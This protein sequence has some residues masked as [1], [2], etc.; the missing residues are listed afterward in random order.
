[1]IETLSN[2]DLTRYIAFEAE[3][4]IPDGYFVGGLLARCLANLGGNKTA[5]PSDFV[6]YLKS[7]SRYQTGDEMLAM[8][9]ARMK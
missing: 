3:Y 4:G 9:N 1:L 7:S 5:V 2:R 6:P 8:F